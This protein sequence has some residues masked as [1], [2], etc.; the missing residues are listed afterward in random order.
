MVL[1]GW[2]EIAKYL[3]CGVR[4]VQRWENSDTGLPIHRPKPNR[5]TVCAS[6]EE[7]DAWLHR[8]PQRRATDGDNGHNGH[9][10]YRVLLVDDDER[11][12]ASM[13]AILTGAGFEVKTARDGFHALAVMRNGS[14][15]DL[16]ISD[17]KMPSMSGFEL[18]TVVRKRFPAVSVIAMGGDLKPLSQPV[19]LADAFFSKGNG[20]RQELVKVAKQLLSQSPLRAQLPKGYTA[21]AWVPLNG[22]DYIVVS[23]TDCL[24]S[25]PVLLSE[26]DGENGPVSESCA[27]CGVDVAFFVDWTAGKDAR[28]SMTP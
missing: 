14:V 2:K 13:A 24:R 20:N 18:L 4:T 27:H 7:I 6:T 5:G 22:G 9:F 23:C 21:P 8:T 25:F 17:L 3:H 26:L 16:L 12:L 1:N 10:Q 19:A 11:T 28:A 15:P